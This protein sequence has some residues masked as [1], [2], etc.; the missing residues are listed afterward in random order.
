MKSYAVR[1]C[2]V[3]CA[4]PVGCLLALL[5]LGF[6]DLSSGAATFRVG[7]YNLNNYTDERLGSRPVKTVASKAKIRESIRALGAD[8]LAVQ[9]VASLRAFEE[10]RESLKAE[11]VFYPHAELLFAWDTNIHVGVLSR[12]PITGCR[13]HTNDTYLLMGRRFRV[14]RGFLEADIGVAPDYKVTLITAHLKSKRQGVEADE[15]ERRQQE[16]VLLRERVDAIL[17]GNPKA[18]LVVLGDLND[19]KDSLA[20]RAI[21]GRYRNQLVDTRPAERNGDDQPPPNPRWDPLWITWTH[22]YGKE[23]TYSRIDY[24]LLSS[25]M[26]RERLPEQCMVLALPNW[27]VASDHRPIM[28]GF[29]AE[30]R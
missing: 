29:V 5:A 24:I 21:L 10:L 7:T 16:A 6:P 27:G 28:A 2:V 18:N 3:G 25:G 26:E 12:F 17:N 30:D 20:L 1:P 9:E 11:G 15:A 23:D 8:V 4:G 22:F 13:R 19:T 14:E